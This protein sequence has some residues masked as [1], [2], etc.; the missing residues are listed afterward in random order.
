MNPTD[1][2]TPP[3]II[4]A[5]GFGTRLRS[6]LP[7][8]IPKPMATVS[9]RPFLEHLVRQL[10][11]VGIERI[12]I[13]TGFLA[14]TIR[15]HF[16]DGSAFGA[17]ISYSHETLPLGTGGAAALAASTLDGEACI[18]MNGDSYCEVDFASLIRRFRETA[19]KA[20]IVVREVDD[21]SRYGSVEIGESDRIIAFNEKSASPDIHARGWINGG[22][23]ILRKSALETIPTN[24]STSIERDFFPTLA[25][26]SL[27][28]FKT[29]GLFIDIGIPQELERAQKLF[30]GPTP[31]RSSPPLT[32]REGKEP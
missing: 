3:A 16:G 27:F 18:V 32:Q 31:A 22:V 11:D 25:A 13:S 20:I 12:V 9:G 28:A 19:A 1:S 29:S 6:A 14:E 10:T 15:N 30:G 24:I 4:L 21:P 5:G 23:Y 26:R 17:H 2:L 8:G 7:D